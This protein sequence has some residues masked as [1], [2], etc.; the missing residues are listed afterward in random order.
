VIAA[1]LVGFF[2]DRR[3]SA[4]VL[5][6]PAAARVDRAEAVPRRLSERHVLPRKGRMAWSSQVWMEFVSAWCSGRAKPPPKR[7]K[8]LRISL[9]SQHQAYS[10][11]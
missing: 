9:A 7:G 2:G 3:L 5:L 8:Q 1:V 11:P 4:V 6:H 10:V